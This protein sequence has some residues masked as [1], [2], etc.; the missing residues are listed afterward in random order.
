MYEVLELHAVF[1]RTRVP[2]LRTLRPNYTIVGNTRSEHIQWEV[3]LLLPVPP[4][5]EVAALRVI[6]AVRAVP[7]CPDFFL[8]YRLGNTFTPKGS[9]RFRAY[10]YSGTLLIGAIDDDRLML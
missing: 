1:D 5:D 6:D 3:D 10:S 4:V 2:N 7:L 8:N 9:A